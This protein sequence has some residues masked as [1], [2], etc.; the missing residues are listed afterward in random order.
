MVFLIIC[1]YKTDNDIIFCIKEGCVC[2]LE[3]SAVPRSS[4][5][6]KLTGSNDT[7]EVIGR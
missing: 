3:D 6:H 1:M 5:S 4:R 7:K 2:K